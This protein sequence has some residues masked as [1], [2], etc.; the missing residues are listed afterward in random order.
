MGQWLRPANRAWEPGQLDEIRKL[1][2]RLLAVKAQLDQLDTLQEHQ[3]MSALFPTFTSIWQ[4][5]KRFLE[6]DTRDVF[7]KA[8]ELSEESE[9]QEERDFQVVGNYLYW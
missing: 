9:H 3:I 8:L 2:A 5:A 6:T 1:Y 4:R 7:Q